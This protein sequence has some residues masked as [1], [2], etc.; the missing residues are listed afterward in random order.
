MST[1]PGRNR[2][3]APAAEVTAIA[4]VAEVADAVATSVAGDLAGKFFVLKIFR[5][6]QKSG[7]A[8]KPELLF[9]LFVHPLQEKK[10]RSTR[11]DMACKWIL[12]RR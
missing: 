4:L 5:I 9:S 1:K 6:A 11:N 2:L 3:V 7:S 8:P 12:I 10:I